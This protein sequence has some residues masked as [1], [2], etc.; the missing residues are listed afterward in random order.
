MSKKKHNPT[1]DGEVEEKKAEQQY[2]KKAPHDQQT[3]DNIAPGK[4]RR[5]PDKG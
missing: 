3:R 1:K 4:G 2:K 5:A